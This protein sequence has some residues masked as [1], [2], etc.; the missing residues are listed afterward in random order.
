MQKDDGMMIVAHQFTDNLASV[1]FHIDTI[2]VAAGHIGP[3]RAN[4][5]TATG[6]ALAGHEIPNS[7]G[8]IK[9]QATRFTR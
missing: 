7:Q 4:V 5:N 8:A 3:H 1:H 6:Q 9:R 2:H